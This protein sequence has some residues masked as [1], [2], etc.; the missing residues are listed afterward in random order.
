VNN[1]AR[2]RIS[3]INLFESG[4]YFFVLIYSGLYYQEKMEI[5]VS[6]TQYDEIEPVLKKSGCHLGGNR[7]QLD[8]SAKKYLTYFGIAATAAIVTFVILQPD[9]LMKAAYG[10]DKY[11]KDN[12]NP[13]TIPV[14]KEILIEKAESINK[15]RPAYKY[16]FGQVAD[17]LH[18]YG[19]Q[20]L[21]R[22]DP[23]G[24][25]ILVNHMYR[26]FRNKVHP[27]VAV[28]GYLS[29]YINGSP[30]GYPNFQVYRPYVES[31]LAGVD[32]LDDEHIRF[33]RATMSEIETMKM[34]DMFFGNY[35]M[36]EP[37]QPLLDQKQDFFTIEND[38]NIRAYRFSYLNESNIT[39]GDNVFN[40]AYY[41]STKSVNDIKGFEHFCEMMNIIK[42]KKLHGTGEINKN[43]KTIYLQTPAYLARIAYDFAF[44]E[45][46]DYDQLNQFIGQKKKELEKL[47]SQDP[48]SIECRKLGNV[49]NSLKIMHN[50]RNHGNGSH[51]HKNKIDIFFG[52]NGLLLDSFEELGGKQDSEFVFVDIAI[53]FAVILIIILIL[54]MNLYA[55]KPDVIKIRLSPTS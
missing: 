54:V 17:F 16:Y 25:D 14:S 27:Y 8:E 31:M 10:A 11:Y 33:V 23:D 39:Q 36:S 45:K 12:I 29:A 34:L 18:A 42:I 6:Q 22:G 26:A 24:I 49:I 47:K 41:P 13:F 48:K 5:Q 46:F 52:K 32:V 20:K 7:F 50:Y 43:G 35:N 55:E 30:Y 19:L 2:V 21:Y 28:I 51:T 40:V 15:I 53:L 4:I 37:L 1:L 9:S 44:D 38:Y 3:K